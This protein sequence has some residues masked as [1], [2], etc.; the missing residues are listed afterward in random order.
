MWKNILCIF[1]ISICLFNIFF[2]ILI[3]Q[4]VG[5]IHWIYGMALLRVSYCCFWSNK[6][7]KAVTGICNCSLPTKPRLLASNKLSSLLSKPR[8]LASNKVPF[9]IEPH[10]QL[11]LMMVYW[12]L[13]YN[14]IHAIQCKLE[15]VCWRNTG[16]N[17]AWFGLAGR[18]EAVKG[19]YQLIKICEMAKI[20][21]CSGFIFQ[22]IDLLKLWNE[23]Y[24]KK[25]KR[26][27][28]KE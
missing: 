8:L 9:R 13:Q 3:Y 18:T 4:T 10:C 16:D 6:F 17:S 2:F 20:L 22:G 15:N 14:T 1:W 26:R 24:E 19:F 5:K 11:L 7:S 27:T 23:H 21:S 25:H 28:T 12:S